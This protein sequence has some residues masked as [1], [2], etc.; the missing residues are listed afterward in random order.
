MGEQ[1]EKKRK[2]IGRPTKPPKAGERVPVQD[3]RS[4]RR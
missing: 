3:I 2:R 4:R 1:S